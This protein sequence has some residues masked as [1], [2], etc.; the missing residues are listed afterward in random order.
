MI[1]TFDA[2]LWLWDARRDESWTFVSLP[3]DGST[4]IRELS[5]GPRRGFGSLRVRV[6]VGATT[7]QTS[8]FPD[9]GRG[10]YVL[11]VKRAVRKA[12]RLDVG[13]VLSATVEVLDL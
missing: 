4:E 6:T 7:W 5:D 10:C 11:P 9:S 13:D 8:I 1:L 3:Q 2:E 12:E